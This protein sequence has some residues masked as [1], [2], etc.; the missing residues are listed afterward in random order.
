MGEGGLTTHYV[1]FVGDVRAPVLR[2]RPELDSTF[3]KSEIAV[4]EGTTIS[5]LAPASVTF[6]GPVKGQ[7]EHPGGDLVV[8][9]TV[10]GTYTV[11]IEAFPALPATFTL[12]VGAAA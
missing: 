12:T 11:T 4:R 7:H 3:D 6:E 2:P 8:G 1:E 5:D 10:P 9:W